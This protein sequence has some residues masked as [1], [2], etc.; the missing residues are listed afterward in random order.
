MD[1]IKSDDLSHYSSHDKDFSHPSRCEYLSRM[2]LI[3]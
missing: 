3:Q 1:S 2:I